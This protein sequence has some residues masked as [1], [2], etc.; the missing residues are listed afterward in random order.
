MKYDAWVKSDPIKNWLMPRVGKSNYKRL[1][2]N[3]ITILHH[4]I[5][6][7]G[8]TISCGEAFRRGED[9]Y[10]IGFKRDGEL[11]LFWDYGASDWEH[12]PY[13]FQ[14]FSQTN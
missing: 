14:E 13:P 1:V 10:A 9:D 12:I 5:P 11:L 7:A 3:L 8:L 2:K 6:T 4:G